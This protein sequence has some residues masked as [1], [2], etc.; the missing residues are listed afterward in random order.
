MKVLILGSTGMLG[1]VVSY[2]LTSTNKYIVYNLSRKPFNQKNSIVC[3]VRDKKELETKIKNLKPQVVVNCIGLLIDETKKNFSDA[4]YINSHLPRNMLSLS[5]KEDFKLIHISTDCV[6]SGKRG[7][8]NEYSDKDAKDQYGIT[9]SKGE[10]DVKL[11]LTLRTSIIGPDLKK[12]GAGLFQWILNQSGR[13]NGYSNVIWSGVTTLELSKAIDFAISNSIDGI[14]NLTNAEAI[15]KYELLNLIINEFNVKNIELIKDNRHNSNKSLIS[16][17]EIEYNVP[18][19]LIMIKE[20]R[21]YFDD[22]NHLYKEVIN[23]SK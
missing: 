4:K 23:F 19:Y 20:L 10:F 13:V 15:S 6:F 3:D 5:R 18:S 11:H 22:N 2:Y 16:L 12:R 21:E 1:H 7:G 14:W 9:K 17:R 8:Y